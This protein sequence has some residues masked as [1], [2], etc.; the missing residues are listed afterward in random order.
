MKSFK[1]Y[2]NESPISKIVKIV[3]KAK[4]NDVYYD[5]FVV[6][7]LD[8]QLFLYLPESSSWNTLQK[9]LGKYFNITQIT[10]SESKVKE[11]SNTFKGFVK[12]GIAY[13]DPKISPNLKGIVK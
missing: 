8:D 9:T 11:L 12:S 4:Q 13:I 2:M 1:E 3:Y 6:N 5:I 10:Q 7:Q